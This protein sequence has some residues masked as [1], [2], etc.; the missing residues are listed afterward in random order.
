MA[1][2][3]S[4]RVN[5]LVFTHVHRHVHARVYMH[6]HTHVYTHANTHVYAHFHTLV[7]PATETSTSTKYVR[8]HVDAFCTSMR[9]SVTRPDNTGNASNSAC[10]YSYGPY[11]YGLHSHGQTTQAMR[12]TPLS[13][14]SMPRSDRVASSSPTNVR[15]RNA[16]HRRRLTASSSKSSYV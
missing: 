3:M 13:R 16:P 10:L 7:T 5:T 11:S 1:I 6:T 12:V 14:S 9:M 15:W 2:R 4:I 8:I